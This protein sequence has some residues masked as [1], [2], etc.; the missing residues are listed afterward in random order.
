MY[1][2]A[3]LYLSQKL[4]AW[5]YVRWFCLCFLLQ[6]VLLFFIRIYCRQ[7]PVML[8]RL[9]SLFWVED[10]NH[11]LNKNPIEPTPF[12]IGKLTNKKSCD[13]LYA[14]TKNLLAY[15][16]PIPNVPIYLLAVMR[17]MF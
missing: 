4:V 12:R 6:L 2:A 17:M 13:R 1:L 5:G 14:T 9:T 11:I 8:A 7:E 10:G 16:K 15:F 3:F